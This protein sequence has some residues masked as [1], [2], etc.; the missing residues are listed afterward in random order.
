MSVCLS[1]PSPCNFF[2]GL[3]LAHM[4]HDQIPSLSLVPLSTPL[5]SPP[6]YYLHR[7]RESVS[8]VCRIFLSGFLSIEQFIPVWLKLLCVGRFEKD[9]L[10]LFCPGVIA[11]CRSCSLREALCRG[12]GLLAGLLVCLHCLFIARHQE[13]LVLVCSGLVWLEQFMLPKPYGLCLAV[14]SQSAGRAC[15][16]C[17]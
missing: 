15:C 3:S 6:P 17:C 4:S 11:P 8:P 9:N 12:V 16:S 5:E 7:S 1:V 13:G 2:P 10:A 14:G